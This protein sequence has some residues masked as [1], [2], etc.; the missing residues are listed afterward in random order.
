MSNLSVPENSIVDF[1]RKLPKVYIDRVIVS[2]KDTGDSATI[3]I[4]VQLSL[5]DTSGA[6]KEFLL[7]DNPELWDL[8]N[9]DVLVLKDKSAAERF[10]E[11]NESIA[12]ITY[13]AAWPQC[14][15]DPA[16]E[17]W[18]NVL[19]GARSNDYWKIT[20]NADTSGTWIHPTQ[21]KAAWRTISLKGVIM[22]LLGGSPGKNVSKKLLRKLTEVTESNDETFK[23]VKILNG[24]LLNVKF[25]IH[26]NFFFDFTPDGTASAAADFAGD[27]EG[28]GWRYIGGV[29]ITEIM[30]SGAPASEGRVYQSDIF[31]NN[32]YVFAHSRLR[33][34]SGIWQGTGVEGGIGNLQKMTNLLDEFMGDITYERVIQNG[35]MHTRQTMFFTE[36]DKI[37]HDDIILNRKG[38]YVKA[39]N[40]NNQS[41]AAAITERIL[42]LIDTETEQDN[43]A[44]RYY[45]YVI[46]NMVGYASKPNMFVKLFEQLSL[47]PDR[48]E[49]NHAGRFA[50]AFSD[51]MNQYD[52]FFAAGERVYKKI[53]R[54]PK[55][56]DLRIPAGVGEIPDPPAAPKKHTKI[57]LAG[58]MGNISSD[59]S[60]PGVASET[61]FSVLQSADKLENWWKRKRI[62]GYFIL[63]RENMIYDVD[64]H[65]S[66]TYWRHT[67][68]LI[69][70]FGWGL[71]NAYFYIDRLR[72]H[73]CP[74]DEDDDIIS[75]SAEEHVLSAQL[76]HPATFDPGDGSSYF[77]ISAG[78]NGTI[79]KPYTET[80]E[81]S[82]APP[83]IGGTKNTETERLGYHIRTGYYDSGHLDT[84]V[85]FDV[86]HPNLLDH[87]ERLSKLILCYFTEPVAGMFGHDDPWDY[88][89]VSGVEH[90][91]NIKYTADYTIVNNLGGIFYKIWEH[92]KFYKGIL[93]TYLRFAERKCSFD[94]RTGNFNE[95]FGDDF[96]ALFEGKLQTS[97]W[98]RPASMFL[99]AEDI[100]YNTYGGNND[101]I[102]SKLLTLV[103]GIDPKSGTIDQLRAFFDTYRELL[104]DWAHKFRGQYNSTT[105]KYNWHKNFKP[106]T[107]FNDSD[108]LGHGVYTSGGSYGATEYEDE[109]WKLPQGSIN[110]KK[111]FS[112][113]N[114]IMEDLEAEQ[115]A[116]QAQEEAKT[117][118]GGCGGVAGHLQSK[119]STFCN[120]WKRHATGG[121]RGDF[122]PFP[123][124]TT[125]KRNNQGDMSLAAAKDHWA[126]A[127]LS[128]SAYNEWWGADHES[129]NIAFDSFVFSARGLNGN[130]TSD[131]AKLIGDFDNKGVWEEVME[132]AIHYYDPLPADDLD[133]GQDTVAERHLVYERLRRG[134]K[135]YYGHFMGQVRGCT[136]LSDDEII[137]MFVDPSGNNPF[138]ALDMGNWG[139]IT[140]SEHDSIRKL[141]EK[142][143][144]MRA[145]G[146]WPFFD[147]RKMIPSANWASVAVT[148]SP[149]T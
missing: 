30:D 28:E 126:H 13:A 2:G 63:N 118:L 39:L 36:D 145:I 114:N 62:N 134:V 43:D 140:Q 76:T 15:E 96:H 35:Y 138:D 79:I 59:V 122:G 98:V 95:F 27:P 6:D 142:L 99:L 4:E 110:L 21:V 42:P 143:P 5:K 49:T 84:G 92:L 52:V 37:W 80:I 116:R 66:D 54:N 29:D 125:S 117:A 86:S 47:M 60:D 8:I 70:H 26:K 19:G 83:S 136:G 25:E 69:H 24:G 90:K 77:N 144:A 111:T 61:D 149:A 23:V 46:S 67:Q 137:R 85:Y 34:D 93:E 101:L 20:K 44:L 115:A 148:S 53:V 40:H 18:R 56:L 133:G 68:K 1:G 120:A 130:S 124:G 103:D 102:R 131:A 12:K 71:I 16:C 100:L 10:I 65:P 22:H 105:E 123:K 129:Q 107:P 74:L 121:G 127:G 139:T 109:E 31:P 33:K 41:I 57:Y 119:A 135:R 97:W 17:D 3:G 88:L 72:I 50:S 55:L 87:P 108:F 38:Q 73:R 81:G 82:G 112:A 113:Y 141:L 75:K 9:I 58:D 106:H 11:S 48:R 91:S 132:A 128:Y 51:L 89:M 64:M 45:S 104:R 146:F 78:L 147:R 14:I 94:D 32:V 7:F